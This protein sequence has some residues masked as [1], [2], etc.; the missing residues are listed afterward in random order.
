MSEQIEKLS[1]SMAPNDIEIVQ[2]LAAELGVSFSAANRIIIR[3]WVKLTK[4]T[5]VQPAR[6]EIMDE[7]SPA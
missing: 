3:E 1:V 6:V 7:S 2:E 5:P 4:P